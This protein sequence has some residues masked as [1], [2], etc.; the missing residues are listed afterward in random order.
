[1]SLVPSELALLRHPRLAALASGACPAWLWSTDA[2]RLIWANAAGAALFGATSTAAVGQRHFDPKNHPAAA[3][4]L[5]LAATLPASGAPRLERLRGLGLL[6]ALTCACSRLTLA[7]G[8]TAVLIASTE[9][10]GPALPLA[11]RIRRLFGGEA[12]SAAIA[13]FSPAG[14]LLYANAAGQT[15]LG[16]FT[17]LAALGI[18]ALGRAALEAGS[19]SGPA[20][21]DV[22]TLD[23]LGEGNSRALVLTLSAAP[24]VVAALTAPAAPEARDASSAERRHPLR[25]VWQMDADGRFVVG[26]DEFIELVGPQTTAAFGRKW[27]DVATEV[28]L[29]PDGLVARAIESRETWSGIVVAW[30]VDDSDERLPVE[31]SGLPVFDRDRSFRGYR[32]F[33]VCRDLTRINQLIRVRRERPAG[34]LPMAESAIDAAAAAEA[35]EAETETVAH[36]ER[37]ALAAAPASANV[38]PFR[39]A[40]PEPKMPALSPVERRAFRELAQ[41]LTARLRG[42][43]EA[44]AIGGG[45]RAGTAG[46]HDA[47]AHDVGAHD[48]DAAAGDAEPAIH[49]HAAIRPAEVSPAEFSPVETVLLD[50]VPVGILVYRHDTLLFAN[51]HLLEGSGYDDLAALAAAGGLGAL[52]AEADTPAEGGGTRLLSI[53]TSG[54]ALRPVDARLYS[55]PWQGAAALVLILTD[56]QHDE[57]RGGGEPEPATAERDLRQARQEVEQAEA[58]KAEF[59]AKLSQEVRTP[60]NTITGFAEVIMGERFGP[61][62]NERYRDYLRDIHG[63]GTQLAA[64][65][66]NLLDLT[67]IE[68]GRFDLSFAEVNLNELTQQCVGI[69][70]PQAN[71]ARIIIRSALTRGLPKVVGDERA[72]RQ[73]V[74]NLLSNAIRLTGPGGQVIVSTA[75]TGSEAVLRVRDTGVGMT[76]EEIA[77]ALEPFAQGQAGAA[78]GSGGTGLSLSLT[79]ALAE[80]NRAIFNIKSAPNAGTLVE[81]VFPEIRAAAE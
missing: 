47:G 38:V 48:A 37:A 1:M 35:A 75:A 11:E 65:L 15:Q 39:Q 45:A 72:L 74:L 61:I 12:D 16:G 3:A 18:E 77:V 19:A 4:A 26:S 63:A 67:K 51:R 56:R 54:G 59:L 60:L 40:P 46:A 30:P 14:A 9:P 34:V 78:W 20:H 32:G 42:S 71:R 36:L 76:D 79:R 31:L 50:R 17:T 7:D 21:R 27:S 25:F 33:G 28:K 8:T 57:R 70:Q 5:R 10:A 6:R 23:R 52:F 64:M 13:V 55:A 2:S 73:I 68:S 22:A 41:E 62:G 53:K 81:I 29:D 49:S 43:P 80:A 66:N 44:G 58:E 24:P 69:M